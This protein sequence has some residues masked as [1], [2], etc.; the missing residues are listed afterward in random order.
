MTAAS[1]NRL[2]ELIVARLTGVLA[3]DGF[4]GCPPWTGRSEAQPGTQY[5][6][7]RD[8]WFES[9]NGSEPNVTAVIE[10]KL[11]RDGGSV[12]LVG[13]AWLM[14]N[15]VANVVAE[16]PSEALASSGNRVPAR[17]ESIEFGFFQNPQNVGLA[18]IWI[19]EE[20]NVD[21]CVDLFMEYMHGSVRDWLD[22]R[23]NVSDLLVLA[24]TATETA[25]DRSN[26][27]PVRLRGTVILTLLAQRTEEA[28]ALMQ[29]YRERK[30]YHNWDS[31]D[32]VE[33]FHNALVAL[34]PGYGAGQ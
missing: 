3:S 28:A 21:Y 8:A 25:I 17:L 27:D 15:A 22:S 30:S 32:R 12:G 10:A 16:L 34:F 31:A 24:P 4:I 26:P 11:L 33:A 19:S 9:V 23:S 6:E 18:R 2:M 13:V 5:P 20:A 14:S 7:W 29:L 1:A